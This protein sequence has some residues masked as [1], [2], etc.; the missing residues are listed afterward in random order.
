MLKS[1]L[2]PN[3]SIYYSTLGNSWTNNYDNTKKLYEKLNLKSQISSSYDSIAP[4][5]TMFWF[6]KGTLS[7]LFDKDWKYDDFPKEPNEFDGTLLHA[8]ERIYTFVAQDNKFLSGW[9]LTDNFARIEI[10]NLS[11]MVS[12]LNSKLMK[13]Y[14]F[15]SAY[16]LNNSIGNISILSILENKLKTFSKRFFP[17]KIYTILL[18]IYKFIFRKKQHNI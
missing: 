15:N 14:S 5:G 6:R 13:N 18:R 10:T 16:V 4:L 12:N 17:K 3:H 1:I 9:I 8:I 11:N 7:H 2:P